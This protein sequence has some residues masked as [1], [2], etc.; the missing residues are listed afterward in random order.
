[1]FFFDQSAGLSST[2]VFEPAE[3][4]EVKQAFERFITLERKFIQ[5]GL[6]N[7]PYY[8][9]F[10]K[11]IFEKEKLP[12]DLVWLPLIESAFS[13]HAYSRAGASGVWQFMPGTARFYNLKIDFWVDE[14]ID[15]FK[16]TR[17]AAKLLKSLYNYYDN[18]ELALAAY[19]AGIGSV[20]LAIKKGGSRDFWELTS[21]GYLKRETREY[22]PR[23]FAAAYI[24][25]NHDRFGFVLNTDIK[26]PE[27][28]ILLV[29]KPIDLTIFAEKTEIKLSSLK[30]LNPELQRYITP[31]GENYKLRIPEEKLARALAVYNELPKEDL[32]GVRWH[33]VRTGETLGEIA[34]NYST[35]VLLLKRIN[36]IT[37]AKRIYAGAKI[38][39]PVHS[40]EPDNANE[41]VYEP[42]KEFNT[43]EI[44]YEVRKGDTVWGIA[45][46]YETEVEMILAVNGLT[47]DSVLMPGDA[48]KL[49]IDTALQR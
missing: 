6:N 28:E 31:F 2:I 22:V 10:I 5:R 15:P 21:K 11:N 29:E 30:K 46:R 36:N 43:Q 35:K 16:S 39:V 19:N 37:N 13:P 47:F 33:R 18:W 25:E 3:R 9:P 8:L 4:A 24:A 49:W 7:A 34:E 14:R 38:L 1:M 12:E 48:I 42:R 32:T 20:N 23:F 45:K 44:Y 40:E 26:F 41:W 27:Y 17:K